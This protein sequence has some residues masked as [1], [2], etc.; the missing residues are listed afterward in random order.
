MSKISG[1]QKS[2]KHFQYVMTC[3]YCDFE[4]SNK[5]EKQQKIKIRL[6]A[7]IC[8]KTGRTSESTL[9]ADKQRALIK[10]GANGLVDDAYNQRNNG[11]IYTHPDALVYPTQDERLWYVSQPTQVE[12]T[13]VHTEQR[14]DSIDPQ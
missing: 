10:S 11:I 9:E 2:S 8:K 7:K 1:T 4:S 6:H 3:P 5:S 12:R 14:T 13:P